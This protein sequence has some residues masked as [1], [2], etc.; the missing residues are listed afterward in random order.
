VHSIY[1]S[2][3]LK[4]EALAF[5]NKIASGP[6][7]AYVSTKKILRYGMTHTL[8]EAMEIEASEQAKNI[9]GVD[10]MEGVAAFLQKRSPEFKGKGYEKG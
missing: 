2:D 7:A 8:N 5:A 1:P 6:T 10:N 4:E 9:L 3:Q